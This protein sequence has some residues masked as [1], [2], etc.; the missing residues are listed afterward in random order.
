MILVCVTDQESCDRLIVA[1]QHLSNLTGLPL[2]VITVRPRHDKA[3]MASAELEYLFRFA[4]GR[5]AEMIVLFSDHPADAV[6]D[7]LTTNES[8]TVIVGAPPD[9]DQ[10]VFIT[11]LSDALPEIPLLCIAPDGTVQLAAADPTSLRMSQ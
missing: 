7:Y 4:A 11:A 8:H 9:F 3:W 10:S 1:G 2:K 6:I 5:K